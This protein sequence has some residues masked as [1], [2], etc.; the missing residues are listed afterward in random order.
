MTRNTPNDTLNRKLTLVKVPVESTNAVIQTPRC[1]RFT[2]RLLRRRDGSR[3]ARKL[4][5]LCRKRMCDARVR[6]DH[7]TRSSR[8]SICILIMSVGCVQNIFPS[9]A[10]TICACARKIVAYENTFYACSASRNVFGECYSTMHIHATNAFL[11]EEHRTRE[12]DRTR[13]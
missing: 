10:T 9:V 3:V 11:S 1:V 6:D 7:E 12:I 5:H 2:T 8:K 13:D 4:H